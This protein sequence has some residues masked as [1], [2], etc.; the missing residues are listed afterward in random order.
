MITTKSGY[1]WLDADD[2]SRVPVRGDILPV[3][4]T[5]NML[6]EDVLFLNEAM[7]ERRQELVQPGQ[8][9][10][11]PSLTALPHLMS[12]DNTV[13][14]LNAF[15]FTGPCPGNAFLDPE[16]W[17][18]PSNSW[19]EVASWDTDASVSDAQAEA[20]VYASELL[21]D[22]GISWYDSEEAEQRGEVSQNYRGFASPRW[23]ARRWSVKTSGEE[24]AARQVV[25]PF[26]KV[27]LFGLVSDAYD[28]Y[29]RCHLTARMGFPIYQNGGRKVATQTGSGSRTATYP[30]TAGA[31]PTEEF[32]AFDYY[33]QDRR[34]EW[35]S[36]PTEYTYEVLP[37]YNKIYLSLGDSYTT[38]SGAVVPL[39]AGT[40]TTA[41]VLLFAYAKTTT[42]V[43]YVTQSGDIF[44]A[45]NYGS[46]LWARYFSLTKSGQGTAGSGDETW[47]F[48]SFIGGYN[49]LPPEV[50]YPSVEGTIMLKDTTKTVQSLKSYAVAIIDFE[51]RTSGWGDDE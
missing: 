26:A 4:M 51:P 40:I 25:N 36:T 22:K 24:G 6:G 17:D 45:S 11:A 2:V 9:V 32:N 27:P 30:F 47:E 20:S 21:K 19:T 39:T 34:S 49:S 48:P 8:K 5:P 14:A 7:C 41:S 16:K 44:F 38:Q 10:T 28:D 18:P 42:H 13:S 33:R 46:T 1:R 31:F 37:T 43:E 3:R 50:A 35:T 29:S 15:S 12:V 23:L